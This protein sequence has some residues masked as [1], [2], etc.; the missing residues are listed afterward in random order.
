[1]AR[2]RT[3]ALALGLLA[4][5]SL[6]QQRTR[7]EEKPMKIR[8][9]AGARVLTAT[10]L[11]DATAR[12]FAALLPLTLTLTDYADTEKVSDLPR[13]LST[14]GA[15]SGTAASAG[16]LT[17]YAPWGNLAIFHKDFGHSRGLIRLGKLDGGV[18][19]L[20][21]SDPIDVKIERWE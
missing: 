13:R 18:E 19:A 21:A 10:L 12:D 11:D 1:M 2:V 6:A 14:K 7:A 8:L 16:D 4:L 17:Y 3:A 20:R 5:P 9:T 15:P